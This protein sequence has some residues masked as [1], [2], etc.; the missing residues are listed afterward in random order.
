MQDLVKHVL[1]E[2]FF[3]LE[4][5]NPGFLVN[6]TGR[7]DELSMNTPQVANS[8]VPSRLVPGGT[9]N[10]VGTVSHRLQ[11]TPKARCPGEA[12]MLVLEASSGRPLAPVTSLCNFRNSCLPS[13]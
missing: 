3:L 4:S 10:R 7:A 12:W 8:Y 11:L 1:A 5:R 6:G 13:S 9:E 2:E